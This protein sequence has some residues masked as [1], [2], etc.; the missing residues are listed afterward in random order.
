M[1]SCRKG[2]GIW[3]A[4]KLNHRD[5][6]HDEDLINV[7][8]NDSNRGAR[9]I[10]SLREDTK[11]IVHGDLTFSVDKQRV[12]RRQSAVSPV[13]TTPGHDTN[14]DR[15]RLLD[16]IER[17][18][19]RTGGT[20]QKATGARSHEYQPLSGSCESEEGYTVA[21]VAAVRALLREG[22]K[23]ARQRESGEG[24]AARCISWIKKVIYLAVSRRVGAV[25][26]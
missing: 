10:R 4:S 20:R 1:P 8:P 22:V 12:V 7:A 11:Q 5:H 3:L 25:G 17:A 19:E 21:A 16:E 2:I 15:N 18:H 24:V 23:V 13:Y 26:V 9:P 14:F 6:I